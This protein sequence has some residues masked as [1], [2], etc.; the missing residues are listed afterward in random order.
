MRARSEIRFRHQPHLLKAHIRTLD[1]FTKDI[2]RWTVK[3][4]LKV[5]IVLGKLWLK[6]LAS[7]NSFGSYHGNSFCRGVVIWFFLFFKFISTSDVT[8]VR[9]P[10]WIKVACP[11]SAPQPSTQHTNWMLRST[12]AKRVCGLAF[13]FGSFYSISFCC[14]NHKRGNQNSH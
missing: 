3:S 9:P 1:C 5:S 8:Y 11:H 6:A 12:P 4:R 14:A 13:Y 2:R 10:A 7:L